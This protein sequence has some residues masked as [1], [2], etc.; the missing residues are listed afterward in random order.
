MDRDGRTIGIVCL[1]LGPEM[2]PVCQIIIPA[3]T[4][5]VVKQ[6]IKAISSRFVD[7]PGNCTPEELDR[8][9]SEKRSVC[10]RIRECKGSWDTSDLV[11]MGE[12]FDQCAFRRKKIQ[13]RCFMGGNDNHQK[14]TRDVEGGRD[15]CRRLA[16]RD[17]K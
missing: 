2:V 9:E 7:P 12:L 4:R 17:K 16:R 14:Q 6:C 8:L 11:D 1:P 5:Y 10:D 13:E 3:V 15:N